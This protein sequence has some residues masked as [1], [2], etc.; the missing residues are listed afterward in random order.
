MTFFGNYDPSS[1][2][3][4]FDNG[5]I[6]YIYGDASFPQGVANGDVAVIFTK[7]LSLIVPKM[8]DVLDINHDC[9]GYEPRDVIGKPGTRSF[10]GYGLAI[11]VNATTNGQTTLPMSNATTTLPLNTGDI[12]R[13]LGIEWGGDWTA[14]TPRDPMHLELHLSPGEAHSLAQSF[15]GADVTVEELI[16]SPAYWAALR[17]AVSLADTSVDR[18]EGYAGATNAAKQASKDVADLRVLV[19]AIADKVGV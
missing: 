13:P 3:W 2:G 18:A 11:D 5:A 17:K 14:N 6:P 4:T 9:W 7:A 1:F 8:R 10:H 12:V 19:Q 15:I 16:A